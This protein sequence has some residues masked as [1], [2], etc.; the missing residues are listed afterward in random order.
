MGSRKHISRK[1]ISASAFTPKPQ[2]KMMES[3]GFSKGKK[4]RSTELPT[5]DDILRTRPF[6][7][8]I[9][10]S[11]Q[12]EV[13]PLTP[14]AQD[15]VET[16]GYNGASI[17]LFAPAPFAPIQAKLTIGE[18]GDKYEEEA[19]TVAA[20][21]VDKINSP[22]TAQ[23]PQGESIQRQEEADEEMQAKLQMKPQ[24]DISD[25]QRDLIDEN[26]ASKVDSI[27]VVYELIAHKLAYD[28]QDG[29]SAEAGKWLDSQGYQQNWIG[30]VKGSGLFCG[31]LMP[32]EGSQKTPVL[33]FKG[34]EPDKAGDVMADLDPIAVGFTAFKAKQEEVQNLISRA[35]GKVDVTGHSL[36][37]A[38]A[39]QAASAFPGSIQKAVTFQAPGISQ[40]QVRQFNNIPEEERPEMVHHIATG[41]IVDLAGGKHLGG[42]GLYTGE[43]KAQFYLH[44]LESSGPGNHTKFLLQ[45]EAFKQ[46]QEEVGIDQNAREA[47]DLKSEQIGVN[48]KVGMYDDNPFAGTQ[49]IT[50]RAREL[51]APGGALAIGGMELAKGGKGLATEGIE[52]WK[53]GGFVNKLKGGAKVIGGGLGSLFGGATVLAGGATALAGGLA[54]GVGGTLAVG[55]YNTVKGAGEGLS[56]GVN[57]GSSPGRALASGGK[58][59]ATEGVENWKQGGFLNKL[60]GGAKVVG[61][62]LGS[63]FGEATALTGGAVGGVVGGAVG[64]IT[65]IPLALWK[66]WKRE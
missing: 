64:G 48:E 21:V 60:K 14:E 57:I 46:Q 30:T 23:S 58:E 31:L 63:L 34:T 55:A 50:E 54:G 20:Q 29:I 24:R 36:G 15:K 5:T 41:D 38:L 52:N 4:G 8:P 66:R 47:F 1:D 26:A 39:Q 27:D 61:G 6:S 42:S 25:I 40:E 7:T 12:S 3:R 44:N 43:G 45:D 56:E 22:A 18:P 11:S 65:G 9:Q 19:D 10:K 32:K 16:F 49:F 37:G 13:Q 33:A 17:P 51:A 62:G 28:G 2:P 53:Q 35:G 59:L